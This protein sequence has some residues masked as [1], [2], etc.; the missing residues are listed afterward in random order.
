MFRDVYFVVD[1]VM[2]ESCS[3]G[4][5]VVQH[6][7]PISIEMEEV[8]WENGV[9]GEERTDQLPDT[10]L[11][12]LGIN[13]CLR[14]G[15][16]HKNLR[17]PGFN[18]QITVTYD[19]D[20]YKC[21]E[22]VE[23]SCSKTRKGGMTTKAN[24]D[25]KIVKVYPNIDQSRCVVRYFEKYLSLLP[26]GGKHG[27]LYLYEKKGVKNAS[28]DGVWYKDS[29]VCINPLRATVK[30]LLGMAGFTKG[31]FRNHSLRSTCCTRLYDARKDKQLIKEISGHRSNAVR[32]YKKTSD[33]L[34]REV[35]VCLQGKSKFPTSTVSVPSPKIEV[36]APCVIELIENYEEDFVKVKQKGCCN[37]S[38]KRKWCHE[39]QKGDTQHICE[40]LNKMHEAKKY[41]KFKV[42]VEI[43][44]S[45]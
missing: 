41:K 33:S 36:A 9:L 42:S 45:D 23:D 28:T 32:N 3:L 22:Y 29:C 7:T 19:N 16:E 21:L 6:A 39:H 24:H 38:K 20:G 31:N 1:N 25:P 8:M 17:R 10:L 4:L 18:S 27:E 44:D 30:K 26:I 15:E 43:C 37:E 35:S 40:M 11:Y 13:L 34:R 5:G 14:G 12:M 2:K